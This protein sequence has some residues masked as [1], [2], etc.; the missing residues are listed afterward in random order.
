MCSIY[1]KR[2]MV[3]K[4]F[5]AY[6]KGVTGVLISVCRCLTEIALGM[7]EDLCPSVRQFMYWL[8]RRNL[9]RMH[10]GW[11]LG[12]AMDSKRSAV[13]LHNNTM[14]LVLTVQA[15]FHPIYSSPLGLHPLLHF[16]LSVSV[17]LLEP[18]RPFREP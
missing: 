6:K 4:I 18:V 16:G 7:T 1:I 11:F 17:R 5:C 3:G 10:S 13:P 14:L 9:M 8:S 15:T 12:V 2:F